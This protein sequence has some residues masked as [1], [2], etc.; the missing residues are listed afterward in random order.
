M[1]ARQLALKVLNRCEKSNSYSNIALDAA[2][3]GSSLSEPDRALAACLVFGV[4]SRKVT[5]DYYISALSSI[6]EHKIEVETRNILRMGLFQLI[7]LD[8]IPPHAAV[9]E[10]VALAPKRSLG[11]VN[12]LLRSWQREG[13]KITL[14][15]SPIEKMAINCSMPKALCEKLT[16]EYG[17][18]RAESILQAMNGTPSLTLRVNS[19]KTDRDALMER[20]SEHGITCER[21]RLSPFAINL[22]STNVTALPGFS[23]GLFFVQDEASQLCTL[24]V[25]A[26]PGD[27]FVDACS[28]PGSKSFGVAINMQDQGRVLSFDLHANKISLIKSGAENLGISIIEAASADARNYIPELDKKAD[29]VLCDVP[30]SGFGVIAK[31]AEIRFKSLDDVS[32]L[33][34]IQ[35]A[36]LENCSR[37]VKPGGTLV[38]STCTLLRAENCE[39]AERFAKEHNDFYFEPFSVN[40]TEYSAQTQLLPDTNRCDGFFIAKFRRK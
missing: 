27:L 7:Y 36:I 37:Y 4:I 35:F 1:N 33:P 32:K 14:P 9:N 19:L 17:Y 12:A 20:F 8:R 23:E 34:E 22:E 5:L 31:K 18:A 39:V 16:A 29:C 28:A 15:S 3:K 40:A 13:D 24:A 21:G 2:L 30:C 26:K 11:F 10:S 6:P 38:Y 25:G